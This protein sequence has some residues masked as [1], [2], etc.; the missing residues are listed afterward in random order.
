MSEPVTLSQDDVEV[1]LAVWGVRSDSDDE[2]YVTPGEVYAAMDYSWARA[3]FPS[4]R[5]LARHMRDMAER[6]I[7]ERDRWVKRTRYREEVGV[8][9]AI[10]NHTPLRRF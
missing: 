5:H 1:A 6:G 3:R 4:V 9:A 8:I 2:R 10:D 7:L